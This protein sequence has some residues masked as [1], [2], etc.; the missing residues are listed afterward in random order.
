LNERGDKILVEAPFYSVAYFDH[1][2]KRRRV[3]S[4]TPD[5]D[6]A[7][8]LANH[9]ETQAMK[10]RTGQIDVK[11]ERYAIETA[12]PLAKHLADYRAFLTAKGNT[13]KHVRMTCN[14]IKTIGDACQAKYIGDLDGARVMQV[15]G[16]LRDGGTGLRTCNSYLQSVKSFTRW[17]W[18]EKRTPDDAL[19]SL[20][21]F[22]DET[23]RRHVRRELTPDEMA[24]L[25]AFTEGYTTPNHN[26]PGPDRAM[27][28]RVA[29][30]TGFRARELRSLTPAS[31]DL[32][33]D[34]PAVIATAAYVKRRRKDVQPIRR[35]L[36]ELVRPWLADRP[37]GE[38]VFGKLP[39]GTARMMRS[40]LA[41]ARRDWVAAAQTDVDRKA[42]EQSDFLQYEDADGRVVD[43]HAQRHTYISG[44]V[45]GG[46]SV[47][48]A[49]ELARHSTPVLT[50]GR[51]SHARLHDLQGALDALPSTTPK[52]TDAEPEATA[53]TGTDDKTA[54]SR[55]AHRGA[56]LNGKSCENR[57]E[58]ANGGETP[59][60]TRDDRARETAEPQTVKLSTLGKEKATVASRGEGSSSKR[61][62]PDSNR[63]WRI[64]NPLP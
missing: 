43:F 32:D 22:N 38:R 4:R 15:I 14:H 13:D 58:S 11:Q 6:A 27:V 29:L 52:E 9:L 8:Q 35:D 63:R 40:D 50:I 28:Y 16:N 3:S 62:R 19:V 23:D 64:C 25:L 46:A 20:S 26:L 45:A 33:A 31:F 2:G 24:Y 53:A 59:K 57:L 36:A 51:Y 1:N 34:P 21:G 30:G 17:L 7:Q 5:K 18:R 56:Q 47:K 48:T 39:E 12:K 54:D 44:I 55:W 37:R 42:R 49:Q 41:G 61:R 60:D 10:R